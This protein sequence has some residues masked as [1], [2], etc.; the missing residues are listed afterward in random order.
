LVEE[1]YN[2][3]PGLVQ[4]I[5]QFVWVPGSGAWIY[6]FTQEWPVGGVKHQ[7]SYTLALARVTSPSGATGIG[8]I[9]LNYRYQLVGDSEATTAVAPRLSL[10]L[11]TG[12][13]RRGLGAGGAGLQ[14]NVPLSVVLSPAFQANANAGATWIS[15]AEDS[16]GDRAHTFG[17]NL[18]SS[19]IWRGSSTF[20]VLV[21]AVWIHSQNPI[22]PG[23]TGPD[24]IATISPGVRWAYNFPSGLQIV[25]GLGMPLGVGKHHDKA[26]LF[27]LSFEH[28][29]TDAR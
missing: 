16:R 27:Y 24:H 6:T 1:A 20:D 12:N 18:G 8:D 17:S 22:A 25:P 29:F 5:Q 23:R 26:V 4:H 9:F 28:P 15:S 13:G 11:P 19:L 3:D 14:V 10:I 7:L 2:Q 21:E